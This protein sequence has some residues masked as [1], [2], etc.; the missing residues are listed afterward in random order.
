MSGLTFLT[1]K[2]SP[3]IGSFE[4]CENCSF[5]QRGLRQP[6]CFG[7]L[8]SITLLHLLNLAPW[9]PASQALTPTL[10]SALAS[11]RLLPSPFPPPSHPPPRVAF[12]AASPGRIAPYPRPE[13]ASPTSPSRGCSSEPK[14]PRRLGRLAGSA[15]RRSRLGSCSAPSRGWSWWPWL[16]LPLPSP[17]RIDSFRSS[18]SPSNLGLEHHL[19]CFFLLWFLPFIAESKPSSYRFC[20]DVIAGRYLVNE[21]SSFNSTTMI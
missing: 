18:G 4:Y 20:G 1:F 9:I 19:P 2:F 3:Q 13:S 12:R 14:R 21:I 15:R 5:N 6:L 10:T 8:P 17:R 16:A 11:G 7:F